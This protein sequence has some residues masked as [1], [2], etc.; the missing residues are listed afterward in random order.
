MPRSRLRSSVQLTLGLGLL[1]GISMLCAVGV[2]FELSWRAAGW[3]IGKRRSDG[4]ADL[5][6]AG[7]EDPLDGVPE[8]E[9]GQR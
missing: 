3:L 1:T 9:R 7:E 5:A 6:G 8:D 4:G 2:F